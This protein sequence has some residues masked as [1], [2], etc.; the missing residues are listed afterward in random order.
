MTKAVTAARRAAQ[1]PRDSSATAH[2]A[3]EEI[4]V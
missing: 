3:Q 1:P 4:A 2:Q